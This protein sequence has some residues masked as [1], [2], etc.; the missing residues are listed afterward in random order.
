MHHYKEP[1]I[2]KGF[3]FTQEEIE[4][5]IKNKKLL[6]IGIG[7]TGLCNYNCLYCFTEA[8]KAEKQELSNDEIKRVLKDAAKLGAK[9][10]YIAESGEPLMHEGIEGL[11]DYANSLGMW[12]VASTN[13]SLITDEIAKSWL[14]KKVSFQVKMHSINQ[15][16]N[17][18]LAGIS[19]AKFA[20]YEGISLPMG[21]AL[22]LKN[23]YQNAKPPRAGIQATILKQNLKELPEILRAGRKLGLCV[24]FEGLMMEGHA[25]KHPELVPSKKE[26]ELLLEKLSKIDSEEFGMQ[27]ECAP[28]Y[29]GFRK[30][31]E[32]RLKYNLVID[33]K[34][35]AKVCY[36]NA[37]ELGL[38]MNVREHSL[39]EIQRKKFELLDKLPKGCVC[40]RGLK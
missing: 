15:N 21:L 36:S 18:Q 24:H 1:P 3:D 29:F 8:G 35:N 39:K 19:E 5:A 26:M 12:V 23:G 4:D 2:L 17:V 11:V 22:L 6:Q 30:N 9:T 28:T 37:P 38:G 16:M 34:G 33:S 7:T 27:P 20:D 40:I 32:I 31:C 10:W 13:G 25:L 14:K